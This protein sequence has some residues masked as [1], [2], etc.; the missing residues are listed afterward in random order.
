ME[1]KWSLIKS[2]SEGIRKRKKS[3]IDDS[4]VTERGMMTPP[5]Q[6]HQGADR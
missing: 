1:R 5:R 6:A 2:F 4:T 3:A